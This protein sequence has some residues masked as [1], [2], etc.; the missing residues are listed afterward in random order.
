MHTLNIK[1]T[2]YALVVLSTVSYVL[3][4]LFRPLFPAW[5][6]YDVSLWQVFLPGFSWTPAGLLLGLLW[7]VAYAIFAALVF[8][9]TYNFFVR[10]QSLA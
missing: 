3:C 2:V 6:M 5:P 9:N 8:G 4:A 1:A 10:R 7:I